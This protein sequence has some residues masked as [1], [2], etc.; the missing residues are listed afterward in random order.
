MKLPCHHKGYRHRTSKP[1]R[2]IPAVRV[3]PNRKEIAPARMEPSY[4]KPGFD[5]RMNRDEIN[6]CP[7]KSYNGTVFLIS[8]ARDLRAAAQNL[9]KET[10]LGFDTETRPAFKKG[11]TYLPSLLQLAGSKAI[12]LFQ[13]S[14]VSLPQPLRD[15]LSN[16]RII[17]TGV[18]LKDDIIKLQEIAGFKPSG[19]ADLSDMAV[20]AGIKNHGLRGLAAV[21]LGFRISKQARVSNWSV[22]ALSQAQIT[23]AATDAWVSRKLFFCLKELLPEEARDTFFCKQL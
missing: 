5:R 11:Q 17:K 21:L 2:G 18:A 4:P 7:I 23:Y 6:A 12:Y 14:N 22:K 10:V 16:P 20:Q 19:F 15:I 3:K 13:L 1:G 8:S 9:S